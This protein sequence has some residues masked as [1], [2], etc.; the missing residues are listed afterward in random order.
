M[1]DISDPLDPTADADEDPHEGGFRA[2]IAITTERGGPRYGEFSEQ[3]RALMDNV[4]YACPED[5]VTAELIDELKAI[6]EK[7]AASRIDEWHSP[8]GTRIDLPSR[9]NI[10]LPP[11]IVD[12]VDDH[13][14][15]A[16]VTFRD[17]HL[18]GN[19]AA[20]GGHIAVAF[21][22]LGGFAS[23]VAIQGVSR[24]ASLTVQ[25]RSIT[26]LNT[27]LQCHTWA[28]KID[29][30]KVF[31]KGTLHDGDRLCA[32]MDAL[33]IKLNPGQA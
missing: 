3:V 28:E 21:D 23:A 26:P 17:F 2:H 16:S 20:H 19:K 7:L 12:D 27:P 14:V 33:F 1:S 11:Y 32:E 30:R 6:N 29:G 9:G 13:G 18:G 8:S 4:R 31:I 24:T 5:A 22:D 25:Y 10:T 15:R